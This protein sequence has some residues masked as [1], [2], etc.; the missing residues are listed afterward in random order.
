M[1]RGR[2][3]E[4]KGLRFIATQLTLPAVLIKPTKIEKLRGSKS[5]E[6]VC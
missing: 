6:T 5:I 1:S 4:F 3:L 2:T